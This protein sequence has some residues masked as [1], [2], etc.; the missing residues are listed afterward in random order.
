MSNTS[1]NSMETD[2]VIIGAGLTGL[3]TAH[4]LNKAGKKFIV[5]EFLVT[6]R[7]GS[8]T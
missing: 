3:T 2:I 7:L 4:H 8:T 1:S 5:L 6:N